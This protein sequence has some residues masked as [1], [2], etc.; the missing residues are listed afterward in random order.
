MT[1]M[2]ITLHSIETVNELSSLTTLPGSF[3]QAFISKCIDTCQSLKD[4]HVQ[5][6]MIRLVCVFLQSLVKKKSDIKAL[7]ATIQN[8]CVENSSNKEAAA[9]F[10]C[11]KE[12]S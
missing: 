9:L 2:P 10:K 7:N 1:E 3:L 11:L 8:F 5:G 4:R 6:R 12:H